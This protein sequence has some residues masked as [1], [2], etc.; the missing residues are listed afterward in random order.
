MDIRIKHKR[1][2]YCLKIFV[3]IKEEITEHILKEDSF[4]YIVIHLIFASKIGLKWMKHIFVDIIN[5]LPANS[6]SNYPIHDDG[7]SEILTMVEA[8]MKKVITD[9]E[10]C[11]M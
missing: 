11:P 6:Y 10:L 1:G 9:I 3:F 5:T 4:E 7:K 8:F 2:W